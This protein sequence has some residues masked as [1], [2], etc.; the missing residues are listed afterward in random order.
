MTDFRGT[1]SGTTTIA[2]PGDEGSLERCDANASDGERPGF[3]F[4]GFDELTGEF[5]VLGS[6][7]IVASDCIDP[8][9]GEFAQG[10][11]TLTNADGDGIMTEFRGSVRPT[12]DSDIEV[13]RGEHQ[14]V[15]GTGRF[16]G[17]DGMIV[18]EF[19]VRVSTSEITGTCQGQ[20]TV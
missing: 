18:C 20:I 1:Y 8:E 11:A 13:G 14:V 3:A 4:S 2:S 17:A 12:D 19:R 10:R 15:G 5:N 16:V 6:V 7:T 9:R